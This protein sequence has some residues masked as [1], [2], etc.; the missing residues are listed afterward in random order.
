M[1][2][3]VSKEWSGS[4][5]PRGVDGDFGSLTDEEFLERTA[6]DVDLLQDDSV[7]EREAEY[8]MIFA[9][10]SKL[11]ADHVTSD[12]SHVTLAGDH[13]NSDG[14]HVTLAGDHVT[15]D[16]SHVTLDGSHAIQENDHMTQEMTAELY[17]NTDQLDAIFEEAYSQYDTSMQLLQTNACD[18]LEETVIENK[19]SYYQISE[20]S[21]V[22][23]GD[24]F[25]MSVAELESFCTEEDEDGPLQL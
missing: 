17:T 13:V 10:A 11:H 7:S 21:G 12:G 6:A 15:S 8:D 18:I 24:D 16:V 9:E 25:N 20:D 1:Q 4:C 3:Q 19:V 5:E 14:G 2:P 23:G 22:I